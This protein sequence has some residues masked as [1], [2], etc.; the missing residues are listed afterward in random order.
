MIIKSKNIFITISNFRSIYNLPP[1][2]AVFFSFKLGWMFYS[3]GKQ[4]ADQ[5]KQNLINRKIEIAWNQ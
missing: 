5:V 3:S 4:I 2:F 1:K